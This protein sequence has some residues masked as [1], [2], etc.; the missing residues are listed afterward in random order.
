MICMALDTSAA[1]DGSIMHMGFNQHVFDLVANLRV[2]SHGE[3][4]SSC[5]TNMTE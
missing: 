5:L 4:R 3:G 2:L 1:E